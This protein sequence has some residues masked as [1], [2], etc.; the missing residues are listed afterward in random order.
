MDTEKIWA[1][2]IDAFV[3]NCVLY[4]IVCRFRK[5]KVTTIS[6]NRSSRYLFVLSFV[7]VKK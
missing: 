4:P 2:G 6:D 3:V 1:A 7:F 5:V